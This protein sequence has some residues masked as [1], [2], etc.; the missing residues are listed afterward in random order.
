MY[1]FIVARVL[2]REKDAETN[3]MMTM[4]A[5]QC[6]L[7]TLLIR[8]I[9]LQ[10]WISIF[11]KIEIALVLNLDGQVVRA[12]ASG[13]VDSGLIPGCVKPMTLKLVFTASLLDAQHHGNSLENKSASVLVLLLENTF[14]GIS[15]SSCG[16][17]MASNF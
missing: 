13:A 15:P 1:F 5:T 3:E 16:R 11:A 6:S 8:K 7:F 2:L 4:V 17:Q 12:F 10:S 14:S 9:L